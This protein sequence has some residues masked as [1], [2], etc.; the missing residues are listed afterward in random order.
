M[1]QSE[2]KYLKLKIEDGVNEAKR[3]LE[4]G[5]VVGGDTAF[6]HA[7]SKLNGEH[8]NFKPLIE[9]SIGGFVDV[10]ENEEKVGYN[11][12]R[13]AIEYPLRQIIENSGEEPS[14]IIAQIKTS[15]NS[16]SGYNALTNE[17]V[18]DMFSCGIIDAVKVSRT[19]LENAVSAASM[20]LTIDCSITEQEDKSV[21]PNIE[22]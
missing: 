10:L 18:P 2:L 1:L 13:K 17:I 19:V 11:I 16:N 21:K 9:G 7:S 3:A 14:V 20:F 5:I 15:K 6:I 22:Y 4:E 12:I 8:R